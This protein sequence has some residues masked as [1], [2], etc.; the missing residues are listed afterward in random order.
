MKSKKVKRICKEKIKIQKNKRYCMENKIITVDR[1]KNL[2]KD[3]KAP[4]KINFKN[5]KYELTSA[6]LYVKKKATTLSDLFCKYELELCPDDDISEIILDDGF[7]D[8]Q[9]ITFE[10]A[11]IFSELSYYCKSCYSTDLLRLLE[12]SGTIN[13]LIE[14]QK[15]LIE[16]IRK[17]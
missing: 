11:D 5:E 16:M 15:K 12:M 2:I 10:V 8:I 13:N 1:L 9:K 3:S 7:I 17:I 6:G 14:N 4:R